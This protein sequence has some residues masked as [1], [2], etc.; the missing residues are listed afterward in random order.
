MEYKKTES[1]S[2]TKCTGTQP[3]HSLHR[4]KYGSALRPL[5]IRNIDQNTLNFLILTIL[6]KTFLPGVLCLHLLYHLLAKAADLG[7][8]LDHHVLCALVPLK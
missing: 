4:L 2:V 6:L 5:R 7:G 1:G 3:G 8:T